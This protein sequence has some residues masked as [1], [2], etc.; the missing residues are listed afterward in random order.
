MVTAT[1]TDKK[2]EHYLQ[3]DGLRGLAII[4]VVLQHCNLLVYGGWIVDGIFFALAG[5][6]LIN[7]YKPDNEKRFLSLWGILRFYKNRA[8][9]ILPAYYLILLIVFVHSRYLWI[10]KETFISL[11]YFG[12]I[13]GTLWFMY[14]YFWLMFIIPYFMLVL[15]LFAKKIRV[16]NND[17]FCAAVFVVLAAVF[18]IIVVLLDIYDIRFEQLFIGISAGYICRYIRNN[19]KLRTA[20]EKHKVLGESLILIILVS[21]VAF[22]SKK[23]MM[24]IDPVWGEDSVGHRYLFG[25]G[26][27]MSFLV[28][29][30]GLYSNGIVSRLL[31]TRIMVFLGKISYTVYLIHIFIMLQINV[32]SDVIWFLCTFSISVVL[33][34]L[35]DT[36]ISFVID[37][38][39]MLKEKHAKTQI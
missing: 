9:R 11:L 5:F 19:E 30:L 7:P 37:K 10:P 8:I 34:Y 24:M 33:A 23:L 14:A 25:T 16:L 15:Q 26:I 1:D 12:D 38:C 35:I 3:F 31:S 6:F 18:R 20:V 28:I 27:V 2:S 4:F 17:L 32:K 29:L 22:S 21:L 39:K 36:A 13:W